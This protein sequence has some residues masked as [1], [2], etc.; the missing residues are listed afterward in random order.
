MNKCDQCQRLGQPLPSTKINLIFVNPSL[1][2]EIWVI[3]FIGP[4]LT[5]GRW[6]RAR[7]II[8]KFKYITKWAEVEPI[9]SLS[10]DIDAKF[11][12]ENIVTRFG[13][14]LTLISDQGSHFLNKTIITLTKKFM[15]E[16]RKS[17]VY[18]PQSNG[19]IED[20]KKT[21]TR[22]LTKICNTNKYY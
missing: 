6:T 15:I 20:F 4:F 19:A 8:T 12:Y 13:C 22:E 18:H 2:L 16:H 5:P 11:T 17:T 10:S 9:E 14:P 7:Y 21:L 1:T 3:D